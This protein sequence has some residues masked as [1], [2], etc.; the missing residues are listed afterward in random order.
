MTITI[1][2]RTYSSSQPNITEAHHEAEFCSPAP[3]DGMLTR[4]I[5]IKHTITGKQFWYNAHDVIKIITNEH[6][7]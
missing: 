7:A 3:L 1:T 4:F 5:S 6:G 2:Y